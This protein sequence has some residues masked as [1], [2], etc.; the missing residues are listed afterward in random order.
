MGALSLLRTVCFVQKKDESISRTNARKSTQTTQQTL[1][2]LREEAQ[3]CLW[4][5][6]SWFIKFG[7]SS[8]TDNYQDKLI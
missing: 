1:A 7:L 2:L 4:P 6:A 3:H 8:K 5:L